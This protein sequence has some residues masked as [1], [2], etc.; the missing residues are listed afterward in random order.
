MRF[1]LKN[2]CKNCPFRNDK[3]RIRFSGTARAE[4]IEESA[5]RSGFPCHLSAVDT[6]EDD[7]DN[8]GYVAGEHTQHCAGYLIMKI[9]EGFETSWPGIDN[10]EEL[11]DRLAEQLNLKAPVF[12]DVEE[13][14]NA[15][16]SRR[17]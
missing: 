12:G 14:I 9:N 1:D 7:P 10:D 5:Y 3:T 15:N 11:Y 4:E 8:G 13:F 17:K 2:P 6:S 16:A